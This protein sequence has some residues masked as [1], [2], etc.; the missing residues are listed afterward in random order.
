[1]KERTRKRTGMRKIEIGRDR[2]K[3]R[4][5]STGGRKERATLKV[6]V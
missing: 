2:E 1:M 6:I 4:Q 3:E 5:R